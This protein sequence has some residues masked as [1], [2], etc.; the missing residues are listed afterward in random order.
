MVNTLKARGGNDNFWDDKYEINPNNIDYYPIV[1]EFPSLIIPLL[2][3][4]L[5]LTAAFM[6]RR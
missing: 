2:F 4:V 6:K 1:P 3:M 5:T